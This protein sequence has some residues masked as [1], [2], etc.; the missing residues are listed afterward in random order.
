MV[1]IPW[2]SYRD[3]S[4]F[5]QEMNQLFDRFF[6]RELIDRPWEKLPYPRMHITETEN[7]ILVHV[8]AHDFSPEELQITFKENAL[9]VKGEKEKN[10]EVELKDL[11]YLQ[12]KPGSFIRTIRTQEKIQND[13]IRAKYKDGILV[14][15]LPKAKDKPSTF[16]IAIE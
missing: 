12:R 3:L 5:A 16:R 14:I 4:C 9:I 2:R 7:E 11:H 6:G 10:G 1:L 15:V 13:A 8:E